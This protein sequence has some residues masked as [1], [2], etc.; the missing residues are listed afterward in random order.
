MKI[1]WTAEPKVSYF[2]ILDYIKTNWGE[3]EVQKF[4][5]TT[6][7]VFSKIA[8]NPNMFKKSKQKNVRLGFISKHTSFFYNVGSREIQVLT[9]WD[10][11]KDPRK[12]KY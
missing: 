8:S 12:L 6:N 7:F 2:N 5:G 9:F 11:R 1:S 10:N 3:N 4:I